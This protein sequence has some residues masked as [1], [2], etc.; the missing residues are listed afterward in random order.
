M[1]KALFVDHIFHRRTRSSDFF[2][3]ILRE[4]F[5]VEHFHL[6]PDA[7]ADRSVVAA[8]RANDIVIL[9][10]K[11]FM[12]P[13]FLAMG[14][15][16]IVIPMYDGSAGLPDLHWLFARGARF[17]NFSLT[18]HERVRLL[19]VDSMLLRY[20]PEPV[21]EKDLPRFDQLKAFFWQ[22]RPDHGV[23][24]EEIVNLIGQ[25]IDRFHM[26][27]APDVPG[28][29]PSNIP[30]DVPFEYTES[31]WFER[32]SDYEDC[33]ASCNLFV[34]PRAS[35]G[36]GLAL[37]EAMARGMVVLAHDAPTHNEY[38]SNGVNGILFDKD[39]GHE[40][41]WLREKAARLGRSAWRTAVDGHERWNA[42]HPA[43][44]DW[45][46]GTEGRSP[47]DIDLEAFFADLWDSFFGGVSEYEG[48]LRRHLNILIE[49]LDRPL[50]QALLL[51][52]GR[53][54][55][56]GSDHRYCPL[57]SQGLLDL[58]LPSNQHI[59]GGWC[60]AEGE[61]RWSSGQHSELFFTGLSDQSEEIHAT[62]VATS[63]PDLGKSVRC[64]IELNDVKVFDGPVVPGWNDYNFSFDP[65]LL[66]PENYMRLSFDKAG[67]TPSD[68]R[69][70]A[71]SFKYFRFSPGVKGA[72]GKNSPNPRGLRYTARKLRR[73]LGIAAPQN[74]ASS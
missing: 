71:V 68:P 69:P 42:S 46:E 40:P 57:D 65:R 50:G 10:Q 45:I 25:T 22:R 47:I 52:G 74:R 63:L 36:I 23:K 27:N 55:T 54:E 64:T 14:K 3:D 56:F 59:G 5:E 73:W 35:E 15:P 34:A 2:V 32:K 26:H 13:V 9:W 43:I 66:Q 1:T 21:A 24:V 29:F 61:W 16:T 17:L 62:F 31:R 58:T 20:F 12:A 53:A 70:M 51:I 11:D 19:G 7:P 41:I 67:S 18:L 49:I 6:D 60:G 44:L 48:F 30:E 28:Y 38:V 37:L 4:R 72:L 39:R 8:A 33:L